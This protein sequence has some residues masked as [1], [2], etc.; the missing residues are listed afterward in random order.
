M[1]I[2]E[3]K[4]TFDQFAGPAHANLFEVT[5]SGYPNTVNSLMGSKEL[6]FLCKSA[7]IPSVTLNT[8]VYESV[9][10]LPR[11]YPISVQNTNI[12]TIFMVDSDHE[13]LKFFHSWMQGV[14]NIGTAGGNLSEFGGKLP[15]EIGYKDEYSCRISIKHFSTDQ[16]PS[17]FYEVILDKAW[18]SAIGD[19]DL[20]WESN[21]SYLT[22]P[23][24][25]SYDRIEYSGLRQGSPTSR[26]GRGSGFFDILGAVAGFAGV[27]QQ[28]VNQGLNNV[29]SVQD[30]VNRFQRV[31]SSF[32]NLSRRIGL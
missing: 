24:A 5:I 1:R 10:A 15:Y 27:V 2:S 25:F 8:A 9:A 18:P 7:Q 26:L 17:R 14:I 4:S 31:N 6:T 19:L 22:L 20:A 30:A 16:D 21:D 29:S 28:T 13:I 12:N 11:Q 32:D 3:F 23:V